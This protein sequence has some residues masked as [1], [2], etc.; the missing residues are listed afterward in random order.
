V[1]D[2]SLLF[3][4]ALIVLEVLL[5]SRVMRSWARTVVYGCIGIL[6]C[7][8]IYVALSLRYRLMQVMAGVILIFFVVLLIE[9]LRVQSGADA[10][11]AL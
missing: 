10:A 11:D 2:L 1:H 5:S 9:F 6:F 4:A 8:P 3:L 7:T